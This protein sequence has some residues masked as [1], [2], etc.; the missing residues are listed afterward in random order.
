MI[1][2]SNKKTYEGFSLVEMLITTVI[3]GLLMLTSA[4]VLSTLI[5]VSTTSTNKARVRTESEFVLEMLRRT[6]KTTDPSN[7]HLYI[8]DSRKFD[9]NDGSVIDGP[10]FT[11]VLNSNQT[12]NEIH[13]KPNGST[14]WIC[15]AFYKG[16]STDVDNSGNVNGYILRASK[17]DLA[18]T[19]ED[20]R[21]CLISE[22]ENF[23]VLNSRFV[24]IENFTIQLKP[25]VEKNKVIQLDMLSSAVNWYFGNGKL[26][27]RQFQRQAII[28]T[29]TIIW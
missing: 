24:N 6:L 14:G 18:D 4:L 25:T 22:N 15:L 3:L 11:E 29:E 19:P 13:F 10:T 28:K 2:L 20:H 9:F 17:P 21:N 26:L 23:V 1:K 16:V 8:S 12:G 5:R 27:N 7:V